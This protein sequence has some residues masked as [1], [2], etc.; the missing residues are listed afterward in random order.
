MASE[1]R[2]TVLGNVIELKRGYD[3][4]G[5]ERKDGPYPIVSSSGISGY[6]VEAKAKAPGVVTGRYGT[7]G[8]V[9]YITTDFWPL[10]TSLYVRDFKGNDARFIS[11]FLKQLDFLAYSDKAAVPG[12]N[13][14]HLHSAP[15]RVPPLVVQR[16]I[17]DILGSLDDKIELN[18]RMNRALEAMA[19]AIFKAWFIDFEPVKAKA[20]GATNFPGMPQEV[21]DQL[22]DQFTETELGPIPKGWKVRTLGD[23]C[24]KPQYG[25]TESATEEAV[26]PRFL[27]IKDINK[28]PWIDW[29]TVPYCP[30]D[31]NVKEKYRLHHGD[32][33]VARMADPGHA[34]MIESCPDA[35][36]ASY[37]IR[38]RP[39]NV[40]W[41]RFLQY[42]LR[43]TAYWELVTGRQTGSTRA[44]LNAKVLSGFAIVAPSDHIVEAFKQ[45]I[46]PLRRLVTCNV[47]ESEVLA[48][49]R[50][51]LLP[52]L[53]SGELRVP[54]AERIV[55]R[56][57]L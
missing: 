55:G 22:P 2:D 36:F 54:D 8:E 17:A 4:P 52:K 11:Y 31:E 51:A 43:S 10:N 38:F 3:L 57:G 49:I 12:L 26:G 28:L 37:L 41:G 40:I 50:D 48:G 5:R 46:D 24:E 23:I 53:I 30:I 15:V 47:R 14:N 1:W 16:A 29:S 9:F 32:I 44:N 20:E 21:F 27:R 33:V 18:R 19:R 6:H 45:A 7:L 35:V 13:R 25:Y 42:W 39:L 34:A 56:C